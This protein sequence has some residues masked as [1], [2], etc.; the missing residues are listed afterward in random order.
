MKKDELASF[1]ANASGL[2]ETHSKFVTKFFLEDFDWGAVEK[3]KVER[4]KKILYTIEKQT[5]NHAKMLKDMM[6]KLEEMSE[7]EV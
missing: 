4:V 3:E 1:L 5:S 7:N 6:E 2:E